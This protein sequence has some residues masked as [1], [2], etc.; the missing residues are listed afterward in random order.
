VPRLPLASGFTKA[1]G[2]ISG[3]RMSRRRLLS[4]SSRAVRQNQE[5]FGQLKRRRR[6]A[7]AI[8]AA[9]AAAAVV[10][11]T[12]TAPKAHADI[13]GFDP[14]AWTLNANTASNT[15]GVPLID[16]SGGTGLA[17]I[18]TLTTANNGEASSAFHGTQQTVANF[19]AHFTYTDQT[20]SG[21]DA[22][23]IAFVIQ[24][25]PRTVNALGDGGGA[26]AYGGGAATRINNSIAVEFNIYGGQGGSGTQLGINGSTGNYLSTIGSAVDLANGTPVDVTISYN[27]KILT[28][29]LVQNGNTYTHSFVGSSNGL[30]VI[31]GNTLNA[32]VGFTGATGGLNGQQ[33]V[34]NFSFVAGGATNVGGFFDSQA[35]GNFNTNTTWN[36]NGT[37]AATAPTATDV[38]IV[39]NNNTVTV[40]SDAAALQLYVGGTADPFLGGGY[41]G[42]GTLN[43]VSNTLAIGSDVIIGDGGTNLA[44]TGLYTLG[45]GSLNVGG[46][47]HIGRN[48]GAVGAMTQT[49][50]G[51]SVVGR[52]F[53]GEG[54]TGT[55]NLSGGTAQV[56][57]LTVG[58]GGAGNG[59]LNLSGTSTIS[60]NGSTLLAAGAGSSGTL[61]IG[62][63]AVLNT[64][65][66]SVGENGN[67]VVNITGGTIN[68]T[69]DTWLGHNNGGNGIINQTGGTLNQVH[70]WLNIGRNEQ[71]NNTG[72]VTGTYNLSGGS[73]NVTDGRIMVGAWSNSQGTFNVS[74]G[75][76]V[77][78]N[79][80]TSIGN[81]GGA[82][83]VLNMTG[84]NYHAG[85]G[86]GW[87]FVGQNGGNGTFNLSG[88]TFSNVG[89][90]AANMGDFMVGVDQGTVGV[91]NQTGGVF[92]H[93]TNG[94]WLTIGRS[95]GTGT[96]NLSGGTANVGS[97]MHI[98]ATDNANGAANNQ[99]T[100]G[101]FNQTG[102]VY[103]QTGGWFNIGS[104]DNSGTGDT[105]GV[106]N[107]SAGTY[108]GPNAWIV[109]GRGN[110]GAVGNFNMSGNAVAN[111]DWLVLGQ[112][113][114]SVGNFNISGSA[115]LH[116]NGPL[117]V[118][119]DPGTIG[120]VNQT[121][122]D[123]NVQWAEIGAA[124]PNLGTYNISG[125]SFTTRG[126]FFV[127]RGTGQGIFNQTGG[128]VNIGTWMS[129]ASGDNNA[130]GVV[131]NG[132]YNLSGGTLNVGGDFNV[133]DVGPASGTFTIS[134]NSTLN[135][136]SNFL[137]AKNTNTTGTYIQSGG[138]VN[139]ATGNFQIGRGDAQSNAN[140][141]MTGGT[142]NATNGAAM[143]INN[144][145][146]NLQISGTANPRFSGGLLQNGGAATVTANLSLDGTAQANFSVASFNGGTTV[147]GGNINLS[148]S[149][150]NVNH[151]NV[152]IQPGW[153]LSASNNSSIVLNPGAGNTLGTT[154]AGTISLNSSALK[155]QSGT[156]DLSKY[157]VSATGNP[158][159]PVTFNG[160]LEGYVVGAFNTNDANLGQGGRQLSPRFAKIVGNDNN[161]PMTDA[162]LR[163]G[164]WH[165]N[166]TIVYTGQISVPNTNGDGTGSIAFGEDF[167]DSVYVAIDGSPILS[168]Q[169]WDNST[170]SGKIT[171]PAGLHNIEF[172]FGQGGG[173]AGPVTG[174]STGGWTLPIGF[175]LQ[176]ATN[177]TTV[178]DA[179]SDDSNGGPGTPDNVTGS[180]PSFYSFPSDN[181]TGN[182][183]QTTAVLT[184]TEVD[185][186]DASTLKLG[187]ISGNAP[188]NLMG[189]SGGTVGAT[190]T[191]PDKAVPTIHSMGDVTLTNASSLAT[192]NLGV[193]NTLGVG[194]VNVPMGSTLIVQGGGALAAT[195]TLS[196]GTGALVNYAAV[197]SGT[198]TA[199]RVTH[200][201]GSLALTGTATVDLN[202]HEL[203]L[204]AA[205]PATVKGYLAAAFDAAG[206]Q[207]WGKPGLT[208]S[209]A[210]ANPTVYSVGYAYGGDQSAQDAGV[211]LHNGAP[212]GA[213]QTVARAVLTGDAN[214][215]GQVNFF[216]IVQ[217][218][219][220]KYNTGQPASYTDGDLDYNGKVDFFD[221]VLL[222]SANY[223]TGKT[224]GPGAAGGAAAAA[225]ASS[226]TLSGNGSGHAATASSSIAAA[227]TVGTVGDG[228]PDFVYNPSTGHLTFMTDGGT[229]TTTGGAASFVSSLTISS[230]SGEL[231]GAGASATFAGGTGATLTSTL[232]SSALTNSPG[233]TDGFDIGAVLAPGLTL[234]QLTADLTVK[235]QSLNGGSLKNSDILVPEP[236]GLALLGLGA[237]GL[238]ARRRKS[239]A[240]A[241]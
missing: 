147:L 219:G 150:Y 5:M 182:L 119:Q 49:A 230:A 139:L 94:N 81:G 186:A 140:F 155:V 138:T 31:L 36:F 89:D 192:L 117:K 17:S 67:G 227:T 6:A 228:K 159:G 229:F 76:T 149:S 56:G 146:Q 95:G 69:T 48:V 148:S 188:L 232:L 198:S 206:N 4:S 130:G 236:A 163:G 154:N 22:D 194:N 234:A 42:N 127:G 80:D 165:N 105:V 189:A 212:L 135:L 59:L 158:T 13:V 220:Y 98:G 164:V 179:K 38:A 47:L 216:D 181:G 184:G 208:S 16:T 178:F 161:T 128:T 100:R 214:M 64:N 61:N 175:G 143:V 83:G 171:V 213:N 153:N 125:G 75:A 77:S 21:N 88:G 131:S 39:H 111:T 60:V 173:G 193:K 65:G 102:G 90:G 183:F 137:L 177:G 96:Y 126:E 176:I 129:V 235:Y 37:A 2:I 144:A 97:D 14:N 132:A 238:L 54:G 204:T 58:S 200:Q 24:N 201:V 196:V 211:T 11:V 190:F 241:K 121:G 52:A 15:N 187:G 23:G 239:R 223:N 74:N 233:F 203:L 109:A 133:A 110:A 199:G 30:A 41:I 78:V 221:I 141:I 134:G 226:G 205:N 191:I 207:D 33:S 29:T 85:T 231:I 123:V 82:T 84:G 116:A 66:F 195:G 217:L 118:A 46:Q 45:G 72:L 180:T 91:F 7:G 35:S 222:L 240:A 114:A 157:Q 10:P 92:N 156:I 71:N 124:G 197:G 27:G 215:D 55:Y 79:S 167:D 225:A 103:N 68:T 104:N 160:L 174:T 169:K 122:G 40:N 8:A 237:A 32:Y 63:S 26:L 87:T 18:L 3:E 43:Q 70:G 106:Y 112:G 99:I 73:I 166:T 44:S 62:D 57:G 25:D 86:G 202:N 185:I 172:R 210:K 151:S 142:F 93:G 107:L 34:T 108:N 101:T 120:T 162:D 53:V 218:L 12:L 209:V 168:D 152:T 115:S 9:A 170:S 113:N 20:H 51:L 19:T 136:N 224:Y 50:G 1:E 145:S 28:E